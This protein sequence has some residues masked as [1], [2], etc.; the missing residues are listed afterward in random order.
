MPII[1][2]EPEVSHAWLR[3]LV[4]HSTLTVFFLKLNTR[5]L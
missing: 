3:L 5:E 1:M 2:K 4:F